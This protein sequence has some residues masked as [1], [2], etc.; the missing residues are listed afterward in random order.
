MTLYRLKPYHKDGLHNELNFG[1]WSRHY[2]KGYEKGKW[3][4]IYP[5]SKYA[6]AILHMH[7]A[8]YKE[9][10][11]LTTWGEIKNK[12]EIFHLLEAVWEP[13]QMAIIPCRGHQRSTYYVS[14]GNH[15]ADQ[16]AK[17]AAEE[18]SSAGV[19][20]QTAKLLLA[21]ELPPTQNYSKEE[22]Q[23]AKDEKGIKEK[24]GWWK[25]PD[26]RHF[27]LSAVAAPLVK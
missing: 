20:E 21:P 9:R 11:L 5:D 6:F 13:S 22:E 4:N 12:E 2:A 3:V 7:G 14:R 26:Q 23:W 8:R 24:G 15:L 25:L 18:L 27:V 10:G 17:R 16:A 1:H 19:P